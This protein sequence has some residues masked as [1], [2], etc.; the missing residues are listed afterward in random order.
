M[1][2][3]TPDD[4]WLLL[5]FTESTAELEQHRVRVK[6]LAKLRREVLRRLLVGRTE[7]E[8]AALVDISQPRVR[9]LVGIQCPPGG[10]S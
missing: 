10:V 2:E 4:E 7:R 9:Q 3:V 6:E 5:I 1:K 8:L